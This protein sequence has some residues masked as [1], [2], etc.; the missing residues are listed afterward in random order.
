MVGLNWIAARGLRH[1]AK[2]AL[3]GWEWNIGDSGGVR[4][5]T[6]GRVLR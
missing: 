1:A 3:W 2:W 6:I 5:V 4:I